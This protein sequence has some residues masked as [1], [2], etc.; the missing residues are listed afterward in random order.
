MDRE[1]L[2][3][4]KKYKI[5]KTD[6]VLDIGGSMRQRSEIPVD[7]LVDIIHPEEAPYGPS[8]LLAKKFIK[9]D[10]TKDKLPLGDKEFDFVL[11]LQ[12]IEDLASPFLVLSEMS[13]VAKRGLIVSPSMGADMVFSPFDITDWLTGGR[14][15]PG[16]AH[17]KWFLIPKKNKLRIIPK[18]YSILY[19]SDF[20]ITHWLGPRNMEFYWEGELRFEMFSALNIHTLIDEYQSFIEK[21]IKLIE[22]GRVLFFV[23][24]PLVM[25]KA[26]TKKLFKKGSGY[27]YRRNL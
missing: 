13:R 25:I 20:H 4:I 24:N 15:V 17:H 10:I 14:R 9:V 27:E 16:H 12:T 2:R 5:K 22:K 11:C 8:K 26:F 7:T 21:N 18:N 3:L 6:R 23:D 19:T 1:E